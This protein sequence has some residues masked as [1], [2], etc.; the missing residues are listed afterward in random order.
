[1]HSEI[2]WSKLD[3]KPIMLYLKKLDEY[4]VYWVGV[5]MSRKH[6]IMLASSLYFNIWPNPKMKL[7]A[8]KEFKKIYYSNGF[9]TRDWD[10]TLRS[11]SPGASEQSQATAHY[12]YIKHHVTLNIYK[13]E[14]GLMYNPDDPR[15]LLNWFRPEYAVIVE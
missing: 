10:A 15:E 3:P 9:D 5:G 4:I 11:L 12:N 1:M 8:W 14:G 6:G 2:A 13:K 7:E